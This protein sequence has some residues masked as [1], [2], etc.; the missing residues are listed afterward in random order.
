MNHS[1]AHFQDAFVS[2]L[3]GADSSSMDA[4]TQQPGFAVYRNTVLKGTTDALLANFPTVERLVG[5]EWLK[6]AATLHA[7]RSPPTDTRLLNYGADFPDF[8]DSFEHAQDMPYLG[9]VARLDL[10]WTHVHCAAEEPTLELNDL[11]QIAATELGNVRLRPRD[12]AR[13]AWLPDCPAYTIWSVN[14]ERREMPDSLEWQGEGALLTR[15]AGR[16]HWQA[17]SA[18]DC[19]FLDAC[20]AHL[21]LDVAADRAIAAEPDVNLENLIIRL[22]SAE[23]F[24]STGRQTSSY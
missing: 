16:V 12:S 2:A 7:R 3:F 24:V 21:P 14:R 19:A 11:A 17:A 18:A 10:L 13:W 15:K 22:V 23:A 5:T 6:G 9:D 1:L 8:L 20:A 4:L